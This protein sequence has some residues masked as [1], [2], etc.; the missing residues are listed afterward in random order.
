MRVLVVEDERRMAT[1]IKQILTSNHYAVDVCYNFADGLGA[2]V[3]PD[4]DVVL[5]DRRLPDGKDGLNICKQMRAEGVNTPVIVLSAHGETV[6]RVR[7]LHTGADD[8][9]VKPFSHDELLARIAAILRRPRAFSGVKL[10]IDNLVLDLDRHEASR[11]GAPI[12]LTPKEYQIL[13]CLM[14]HENIALS[15]QYLVAHAWDADADLLPSSIETYIS[16]LR[17]KVDRPFPNDNALIHT[18]WGIGYK[19]SVLT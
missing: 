17:K 14:Q 9:I 2:A 10:Q 18:V 5:L 8:Y 7:G 11:N 16:G 6:D 15:R 3:D 19:V 12:M 4:Y 1:S 13:A